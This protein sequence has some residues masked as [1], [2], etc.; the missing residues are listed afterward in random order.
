MCVWDVRDWGHK[1][2]TCMCF[3]HERKH[4]HTGLFLWVSDRKML[5]IEASE[6]R[7]VI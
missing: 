1:T 4:G 6:Y 2:H 3:L 7:V 5:C